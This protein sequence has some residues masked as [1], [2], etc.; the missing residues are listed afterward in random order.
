[1]LPKI[2]TG[3]RRYA[4]ASQIWSMNLEPDSDDQEFDVTSQN[5]FLDTERLIISIYH[6]MV[7]QINILKGILYD[8]AFDYQDH[9]IILDDVIERLEDILESIRSK[10]QSEKKKLKQIDPNDYRSMIALITDT[11]HE[12]SDLVNNGFFKLKSELQFVQ[13]ELD[14]DDPFCQ[15]LT[16]LIARVE[17][18]EATFNDLKSLH[19]GIEPNNRTFKI[20]RLFDGWANTSKFKHATIRLD[21]QNAESEFYGDEQKIRWFI[22]ELVENSVKHNPDQADLA[23]IISSQDTTKPRWLKNTLMSSSSIPYKYLHINFRDNGKGISPDKKKW[24][25]NPL[26]STSKEGSGLGLFIIQRTLKKM[27]G[28]IIE[29]GRNG[30]EFQIYIPEHRSLG[31]KVKEHGLQPSDLTE[32]GSE[33]TAQEILAGTRDITWRQIHAISSRFHVPPSVFV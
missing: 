7:N 12:I 28:D 16:E 30:S 9:E 24:I 17:L 11:A 31:F 29:N 8:L 14:K 5:D 26:T 13:L 32:F 2:T 6:K 1:M 21:I 27:G 33:T 23:I 18:A 25:F 10:R 20:K 4:R 3:S 15:N 22:N 19:Q